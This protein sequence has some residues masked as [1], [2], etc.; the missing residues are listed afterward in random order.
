MDIEVIQSQSD[1]DRAREVLE[2][3]LGFGK[4]F[5][6]RMFEMHYD[7]ARGGWERAAIVP[8]GPFRM[9]PASMVFH[10]GQEIFEGHKAYRW[11]DGR[12]AMFRPEENAKRMNRSAARMRMPQIDV[13]V[14][15][16]AAFKLVD[17]LRDWVPAADGSSLY[18]RPTMIAT[19]KGLGVR[20]SRQ[21]LYFVIASPVGPYYSSGFAP[22]AV[23]VEDRYIRAVAGGTG[24][25]KTGGNYAAGLLAQADAREEGYNG[26][27]WLDAK[28]RRDIEEIGA[29]NMMV[30]IEDKIVTAPLTGSILPGITRESILKLAPTLGLEVE[31]RKVS[32]E[33]VIERVRDGSLS[34]AF[35][36]GTAAVITPIGTLGYKGSKLSI[37]GDKVGPVANLLYESLTNIQFGRA[38]DP[39]GWMTVLD[40]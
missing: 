34:E 32:I 36:A 40:D 28:G 4:V 30:V 37:T 22:I 11:P 1:S 20:P 35:G 6:D 2:T 17:R 39:Y 10:Y 31:E 23:K 19:E 27:L 16:D 12:I 5:A 29:M 13:E 18:L 25:A 7:E 3:D 14:Q 24:A 26:V 38:A 15:L 33:E 9:D 21:Y 8:Y